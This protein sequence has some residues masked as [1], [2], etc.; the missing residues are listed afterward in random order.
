[1]NNMQQVIQSLTGIILFA[2]AIG[3]ISYALGKLKPGLVFL[4]PALLLAIGTGVL[5][6]VINSGSW[7]G[8]IIAFLAMF[9]IGGGIVTGIVSLII[10][11]VERKKR[12]HT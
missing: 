9:L 12:I 6:S 4:I 5:L 1:M 8:L 2:G 7:E 3:L 10:F 11:L